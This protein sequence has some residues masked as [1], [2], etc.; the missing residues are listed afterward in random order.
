M[1]QGIFLEEECNKNFISPVQSLLTSV[2]WTS[3]VLKIGSFCIDVL[4]TV[5]VLTL[6]IP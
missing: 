1:L 6:D 5:K 2:Y 3:T 4:T